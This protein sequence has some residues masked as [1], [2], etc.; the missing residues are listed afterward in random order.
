[1]WRIK[2]RRLW[3]CF[4]LSLCLL[5]NWSNTFLKAWFLVFPK[6]YL[7]WE[8]IEYI[9][10]YRQCKEKWEGNIA[11]VKKF[12][13]FLRFKKLF[14]IL[15][16]LVKFGEK[17]FLIIL[18]NVPY[19]WGTSLF[20]QKSPTPLIQNENKSLKC[21]ES[22]CFTVVLTRHRVIE[23]KYIAAIFW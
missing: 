3:R 2:M 18:Q 19:N 13:F 6:L 9:P 16:M 7:V 14:L 23:L 1:M 10:R 22:P 20:F 4:S 15:S 11:H 12:F 8:L 21:P 17:Y 5:K